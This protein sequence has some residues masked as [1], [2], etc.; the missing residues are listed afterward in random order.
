MP[1]AMSAK[2]SLFRDLIMSSVSKSRM[3]TSV[4]VWRARRVNGFSDDRIA[5]WSACKQ[6]AR[7]LLAPIVG[8][9]LGS[10]V[11][12]E[13]RGQEEDAKFGEAEIAKRGESRT[14]VGAAVHRTAAAIDDQLGGAGQ[15]GGPSL[16]FQQAR[17]ISRHAVVLRALDVPGSVEAIEA[18]E[19]NCGSGFGVAEFL[20]QIRRL[21]GLRGSPWVRGGAQ[22]NV[23]DHEQSRGDR[24]KNSK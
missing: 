13:I 2:N 21:D 20:Q 10:P 3:G 7:A 18:H 22:R 4:T 14:E 17:F 1:P 5:P 6:R 23:R 16:E 24:Q 12:G 19:D 9:S 15:R 11:H 8:I